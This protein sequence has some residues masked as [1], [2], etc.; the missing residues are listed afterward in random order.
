LQVRVSTADVMWAG[1]DDN[2]TFTMGGRSWDLDN[3][4]HD[5][6]ERGNADNFELD[7]GTGLYLSG[8]GAIHIHKSPDGVAGGWKLKGVRITVNG[9]QIYSNQSINKWLED[10]DRDW[11]GT[12]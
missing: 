12:I 9:S 5:D 3:E 11:Y 6:F 1:T 10:D 4:G 7:P 2:V 8:L